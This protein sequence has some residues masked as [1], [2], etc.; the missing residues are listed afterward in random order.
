MEKYADELK[1]LV[2]LDERHD[3][4]LRELDDLD[5]R[6]ESVLTLWLADREARLKAA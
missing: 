4:L 1:L 5:K 3:E 6:V 2:E